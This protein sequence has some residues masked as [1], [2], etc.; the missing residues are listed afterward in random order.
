[1]LVVQRVAAAM[2]Y[3]H[4]Y[5]CISSLPFFSSNC[6]MVMRSPVIALAC[7][8]SQMLVMAQKLSCNG[9]VGQTTLSMLFDCGS[10]D[11][12]AAGLLQDVLQLA[13]DFADA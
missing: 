8:A 6:F 2:Q 12:I 10:R 9:S 3:N 13:H 4:R 7:F 11:D 5:R 1:M